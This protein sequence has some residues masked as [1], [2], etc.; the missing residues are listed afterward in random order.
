MTDSDESNSTELSIL[1]HAPQMVAQKFE[2][3]RRDDGDSRN[4]LRRKL[5]FVDTLLRYLF[6]VLAAESRGL[7]QPISDDC[8]P[9]IQRLTTPSWGN[10]ATSIESLARRVMAGYGKPV[11]PEYAELILNRAEDG[12]LAPSDF[13]TRLIEVIGV[14]NEVAHKDGSVFCTEAQARQ[15]LKTKLKAPLLAIASALR[16]FARRP[17]LYV[18]SLTDDLLGESEL[19]F[20]R[21]VGEKPERG[22]IRR[23]SRPALK[24]QRPFLANE[25]GT[26]LYLSPFIM[27][28]PASSTGFLLP[29]LIDGWDDGRHTPTYDSS[30]HER[31][32]PLE[33]EVRGL[34]STPAGMFALEPAVF[35]H[36]KA[37]ATDIANELLHVSKGYV[38]ISIPGIDI[39][40]ERPLGKGASATVYRAR[41]KPDGVGPR[42]WLAIKV[43]HDTTLVNVQRDRLEA[44]YNILKSLSHPCL[45][46]VHSFGYEPLPY[47]VMD[48]VD[49][50]SLKARIERGPLP[51]ETVVWLARSILDVLEVVHAKGVIHRDLKPSNIMLSEDN[52]TL[53]VIDFGIALTNAR[54]QF[55][56]TM[57]FVGTPEFAAPEQFR[58]DD[59]VDHRVD[60]F[61]LGRILQEA[62]IGNRRDRVGII[63][64]G[65]QAIIQQATQPIPE[66][67]FASAAAMRDALDE[68]QAGKWEGVPVQENS[69]LEEN[70]E[71]L[72]FKYERDDVWIFDAI[73]M[74][75]RRRQAIALAVKPTARRRLLDAVRRQ[76]EGACTTQTTRVHSIL[77]TV[78]PPDDE[79]AGLERLLAGRTL[80]TRRQV[81]KAKRKASTST[82]PPSAAL[83]AGCLRSTLR[84]RVGELKKDVENTENADGVAAA[85]LEV[86]SAFESILLA[87][88]LQAAR[89]DSI[90]EE[91]WRACPQS[92]L[93]IVNWITKL[94]MRG[95]KR[96]DLLRSM[97][98]VAEIRNQLAHERSHRPSQ[99][100]IDHA[101]M[102]GCV[103]LE[104][105]I[106]GE[107]TDA[108]TGVIPPYLTYDDER[109]L[110][111][112]MRPLRGED[113]VEAFDQYWHR[114]HDAE[115]EVMRQQLQ[116]DSRRR[117]E[118]ESIRERELGEFLA[119]RPYSYAVAY[120]A[121]TVGTVSV[122]EADIVVYSDRE[123]IA[124][125]VEVK[126]IG[127]R[128]YGDLQRA[129]TREALWRKA[130]QFRAPFALLDEDG[131]RTWFA[132]DGSSGLREMPDDSEIVARFAPK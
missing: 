29:R 48:M 104:E 55:T 61:A 118:A 44:E 69:P 86:A 27:V 23:K 46:K 88:A 2:E 80:W 93:G 100:E 11:A 122:H 35:R 41:W 71:L 63:P 68:R 94:P 75:T 79:A 102:L 12:S 127:T 56:G 18:E 84:Q 96:E 5:A 43:L 26:V 74:E 54:N 51:L 34:P 120:G 40:R 105:A 125:L 70:H 36:E 112:L 126:F 111:L 60:I 85:Y 114:V 117:K 52:S 66:H 76:P 8:K 30:A 119:T 97:L 39:S 123:R 45:P 129:R 116:S 57:D 16:V 98:K 101:F 21:L 99:A 82:P 106:G 59:V 19:T 90:D 110:W 47:F 49:G 28:E 50:T 67:R 81:P 113:R 124:L 89:P 7:G 58:K 78:L 62:L 17:L 72:D 38:R 131:V 37:I 10:W 108:G 42:E 87:W 64:N 130:H 109:Q 15:L 73:E 3:A 33:D 22:V 77:F 1:I 128:R 31:R 9:L 115:E 92:L 95:N 121:R 20:L 6:A 25:D 4:R 107:I 32:E 24:F 132:V 103:L 91:T 13:L 14:R 83:T 65:M 53:K